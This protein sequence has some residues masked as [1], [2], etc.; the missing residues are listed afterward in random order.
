[1]F[2]GNHDALEPSG[3][4]LLQAE[5]FEASHAGGEANV[6]VSLASYGED[7]AFVTKV[8]EHEI[9]QNAV[10][11]LRK[12]GVDTKGMLRGGSRLGIYFVEK[13]P[14]SGAAR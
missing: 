3:V 8:P 2:W 13:A 6:S 1:M 12:Y 11:A 14:P 4:K 10:N 5:G 7:A 9:G